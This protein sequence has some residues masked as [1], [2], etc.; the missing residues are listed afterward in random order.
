MA[1][2]LALAIGETDTYHL[3]IID[4]YEIAEKL[5][6]ELKNNEDVGAS[7][8]TTLDVALSD[9]SHD[10]MRRLLIAWGVASKRH[11][12]RTD[13]NEQIKITIGLSAAHQ[14]ITNKAQTSDDG[15]YTTKFNHRAHFEST[16][17]KLNL[18]VP[19]ATSDDVWGLIYPSGL[20]NGLEP[21]VEH[22]LSLQDNTKVDL[23]S[24]MSKTKQYQSD[25]R[26]WHV[27]TENVKYVFK[28][29][30]AK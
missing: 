5:E 2:H 4:T 11:F 10:L 1:L 29:C 13:K 21:L 9:L 12:P 19:N 14:F 15:Q 30:C 8:I 23:D 3:R 16:E 25:G 18:K 28:D 17:V 22:E 27:N 26:P 20:S 6:Y 7:T 24:G